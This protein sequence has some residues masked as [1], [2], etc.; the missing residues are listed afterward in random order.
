MIIP[1]YIERRIRRPV[2]TAACVI[3]GSTPVVSFGNARSA[4]IATL[5]LNPSR[6]EF[7]DV[8]GRELLGD[9]RR[10]ATHCSLG[11]RDLMNAPLV[12]IAGVLSDCDYYFHR[13]PYRQWFDQLER[14]LIECGASYY[15]GSACHLDLVQWATD[16]AWG[17]LERVTRQRLIDADIGFLKEQLMNESIR[18]ILVNG[19]GVATLLQRTLKCALDE[20]DRIEG[21]GRYP[22]RLYNGTAF[23]RVSIVAWSTNIQSS[24]GVSGELRSEITQRVA[25]FAR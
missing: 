9:E 25:E 2:P 10:L 17:D 19:S 15:D 16:P 13:Q 18:L 4:V 6:R 11:T 1:G 23:G 24:Y 21:L 8:R 12:T 3:E 5:G 7:L 20:V 14:M 22:T